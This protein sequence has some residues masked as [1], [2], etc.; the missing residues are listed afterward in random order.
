[1]KRVA[2]APHIFQRSLAGGTSLF[3]DQFQ[4]VTLHRG[5]QRKA[6]RYEHQFAVEF[7]DA[8]EDAISGDATRA[9]P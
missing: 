3:I 2:A 1:M 6:I 5:R 8:A 7:L 4:E 9:T